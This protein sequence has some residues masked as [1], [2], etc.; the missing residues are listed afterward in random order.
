MLFSP[1][2]PDQSLF[3]PGKI[4]YKLNPVKSGTIQLKANISTKKVIILPLKWT[5]HIHN[6]TF[7]YIYIHKKRTLTGNEL[8]MKRSY[9][10]LLEMNFS[11]RKTEE[12]LYKIDM[13][14]KISCVFSFPLSFSHKGSFLL[15][16]RYFYALVG[17]KISH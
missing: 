6:I 3:L 16:C 1:S 14:S 4:P 10:V 8:K 17:L 7:M 13:T 15:P 5:K 12:S 2:E 9:T 11:I